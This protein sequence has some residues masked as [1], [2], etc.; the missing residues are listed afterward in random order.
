[1][2]EVLLFTFAAWRQGYRLTKQEKN[3]IGQR[4]KSGTTIGDGKVVGVNA[5]TRQELRVLPQCTME[6]AMSG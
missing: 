6:S 2:S 1:M 5:M 4:K 3:L